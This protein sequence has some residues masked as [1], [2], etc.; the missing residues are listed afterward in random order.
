MKQLTLL[1]IIL[2]IATACQLNQDRLSD[3]YWRWCENARMVQKMER[4]HSSCFTIEEIEHTAK[5][6]AALNWIID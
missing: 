4:V 3:R 2:L 6:F 1:G 5:P